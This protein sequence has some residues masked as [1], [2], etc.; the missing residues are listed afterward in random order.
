MKYYV[1]WGGQT[2]VVE[3]LGS[4][5]GTRVLVD[6]EPF[7]ADLAVVGD[8]GLYSLLLGG[9]SVAFA[10]R[11]EPGVAVLELYDRQVRVPI[12]DERTRESKRL[13]AG[14]RKG[15]GKGD[16]RSIM[17]G[18]VKEVRVAPGDAVTLH[19]PLLVLEAMKMENEIRADRAGR[20][21]AVHVKGG[22][23]VEKGALLVTLAD[24]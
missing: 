7:A 23:A 20:V 9:Q 22:Q 6:G 8:T 12:E 11:F 3:I 21:L 1:E 14:S 2:R 15:A 5:E 16:V 4:K 10:A 13:T 19:Q 17:P 24:A 18:V